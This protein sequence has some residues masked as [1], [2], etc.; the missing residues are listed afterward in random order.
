MGGRER[1]PQ[2]AVPT[3]DPPRTACSSSCAGARVVGAWR[4]A[5]RPKPRGGALGVGLPSVRGREVS[6]PKSPSADLGISDALARDVR[7]QKIP[8]THWL[9]EPSCFQ[10]SSPLS[11]PSPSL[12]SSRIMEGSKAQVPLSHNQ[13]HCAPVCERPCK[14]TLVF[15]RPGRAAPREGL[16]GRRCSRNG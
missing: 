7:E 6:Q 8:E 16:R 3:L 9:R 14:G 13:R 5:R 2:V 11:H 4:R 10:G 15:S 12:R 1:C